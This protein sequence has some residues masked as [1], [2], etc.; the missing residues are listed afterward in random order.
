MKITEM[1]NL[2]SA[3]DETDNF[4]LLVLAEN[5]DE[6]KQLVR[7]Y[8]ADANLSNDF[9]I[10]DEINTDMNFDCDRVISKNDIH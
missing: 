7:I 1:Q 10:S 4:R 8:A 6:A 3:Y 5:T 2:F 9:V